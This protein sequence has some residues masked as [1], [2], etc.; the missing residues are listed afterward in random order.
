MTEQQK[1]HWL[2]NP[3][4][5]RYFGWI[6]LLVGV[7]LIFL[8]PILITQ[9]SS[10]IHFNDATGVIGDTI[11]GTTGPITQF[12]G[13]ILVFFTL[14]A[15]VRANS[16]INR[17]LDA[18]DLKDE[19]KDNKNYLTEYW[20]EIEKEIDG[21]Y[22]TNGSDGDR[23]D[24]PKD[25]TGKKAF[26][27]YTRWIYSISKE[28]GDDGK[29]RN[30]DVLKKYNAIIFLLSNYL[31]FFND[32]KLQYND[33]LLLLN[34]RK[35]NYQELLSDLPFSKVDFMV[36]DEYKISFYTC[37]I[38]KNTFDDIHT[39]IFN[40]QNKKDKL[41]YIDLSTNKRAYTINFEI[42]RSSPKNN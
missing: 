35:T 19:L 2:D 25:T 26:I 11:G 30:D 14:L 42:P 29:L 1:E 13:S 40:Y 22:T 36:P 4:K 5:L 21:F 38:I 24:Y 15:Q 39:A 3:D 10:G 33:A 12:I 28:L 17:R 16:I 31:N 7:M 34:L 32:A 23:V 18:V 27:K 6:V 41:P 9:T 20:K 8:I 37:E